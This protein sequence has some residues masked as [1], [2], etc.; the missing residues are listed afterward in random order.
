MSQH[1]KYSILS[2]NGL[3]IRVY[4]RPKSMKLEAILSQMGESVPVSKTYKMDAMNMTPNEYWEKTVENMD[5]FC[6]YYEGWK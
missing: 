6:K 5:D 2:H 4:Q 3:D 1:E